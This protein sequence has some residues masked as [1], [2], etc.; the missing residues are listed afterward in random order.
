MNR[1]SFIKNTAIAAGMYPFLNGLQSCNTNIKTQ[2]IFILIQ[3]IGGN[4]GLNTL[5]PIDNYKKIVEAR[6]NIYIPEHK[7]LSLKGTSA[8]GLHPALEGIRDLYNNN[9]ITFV[10]GVGYENQNYS[11]FR[12]SDIYLTGS[13]SSKVVYTG[14]MARYLETKY[15]NYPDGFPN[16]KETDPPAIKVGDNGTFVFQGTA[17]DLSIVINPASGFEITETDNSANNVNSYA[18]Q[19]VNSIREMLLQ[20]ERYSSVIKKGLGTSMNH[21]K[22]YPK[23]GENPLADQLKMVAKLIKGGLQTSVYHVDLKA[24]DTHSEQVDSHNTTKG[25][26]ANLL[27]QL[28]QAITCFWDDMNQIGREND[29]SGMVFSE[30]GRRIVSNAAMGTDHGSSQPLLFFGKN[31]NPGIIGH[32]PEIPEHLTSMDNLKMQ[33]DFRAVYASILKNKMGLIDSALSNVV[34]GDFP[35]IKIFKS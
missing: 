6:P 5:I 23:S 15:K 11:H 32:N 29:V 16:K 17:M 1:K 28:S 12:S 19:E 30:F 14:W 35:D 7:V 21:S 27:H 9:L 18:A 20:T 34:L 24:F 25:T 2:P 10:Q 4:D 33:V 22:L 26:H 13:D 3:L 8:T 31:L